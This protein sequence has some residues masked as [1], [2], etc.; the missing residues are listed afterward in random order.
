MGGKQEHEW[1]AERLRIRGIKK[2]IPLIIA[3]KPGELF[4]VPQDATFAFPGKGA[5]RREFALAD[6]IALV[7]PDALI[8][9]IVVEQSDNGQSLFHRALGQPHSRMQIATILPF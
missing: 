6:G 1:V 5:A 8:N 4:V 2:T 3:G 7:K 9:E